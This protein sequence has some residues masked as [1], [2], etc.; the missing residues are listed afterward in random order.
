MERNVLIAYASNFVSFTL[1]SDIG[2]K[3]DKIILFG[4][5][6][7]GDFDKESDID[8]FIDTKEEIEQESEKLLKLFNMS[9]INEIWRMKG[10]KNEISIKVGKLENW[11]LRRDVI[12]SGVMLYGKYSEIPKEARYYLL[13]KMEFRQ[14]NF[15]GQM[16]IWRKLYGYRQ[17]IGGKVYTKNG[18]LDDIGGKKLGKGIIIVPVEKSH[19]ITDFLNKKKVEYTLHEIWSDTL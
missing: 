10:V 4:S 17:K 19:E 12:G 6:A 7:R 2:E 16:S 8:I 9:K 1:D 14:I 13:I 5:V 18:F 11:N 15:A 3:I